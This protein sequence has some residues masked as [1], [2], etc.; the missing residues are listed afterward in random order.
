MAGMHFGDTLAGMSTETVRADAGYKTTTKLEHNLAGMS[1]RDNVIS[2]TLLTLPGDEI[3]M[4]IKNKNLNI[5]DPMTDR[6]RDVQEVRP[7][8][9]AEIR[10]CSTAE[11]NIGDTTE[12]VASP[13]DEKMK[14]GNMSVSVTGPMPGTR[15]RPQVGADAGYAVSA[16]MEHK[17]AGMNIERVTLPSEENMMKG[18]MSVTGKIP[19]MGGRPKM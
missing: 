17:L 16:T 19:G 5:T 1:I 9:G 11:M 12:L 3:S 14:A 18:S 2:E 8:G 7:G 4:S 6:A 15:G 13:V 10:K